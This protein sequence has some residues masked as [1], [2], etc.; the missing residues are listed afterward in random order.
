MSGPNRR[1]RPHLRR[2]FPRPASTYVR[3]PLVAIAFE[4]TE[5]EAGR[6]GWIVK[7]RDRG[8]LEIRL[9]GSIG[10][11]EVVGVSIDEWEPVALD[12]NHD[13]MTFQESVHHF[14]ELKVDARRLAGHDRLGCLQRIAES[15]AHDV[16]T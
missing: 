2:L 6:M 8:F 3:A 7:D 1:Q 9:L 10:I 13:P 11:H 16:G 5:G 12:L 4:F 15:A 14:V